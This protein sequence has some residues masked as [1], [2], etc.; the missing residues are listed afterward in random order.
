[1]AIPTRDPATTTTSLVVNW[2]GLV[3]PDNGYAAVLSYNLQW[4]SNTEG[5]TFFDLVGFET[6]SLVKSFT[7]VNDLVPGSWYSIRVRAKNYLGWG[8]FSPILLIQA[9]TYP[10]VSAPLSSLI[11]ETSG[12]VLIYWAEPNDSSSPILQYEIKLQ[13]KLQG[14]WT[15]DAALC[16]GSDPVVV[17]NRECL[18][19]MATLRAQYNYGFRD[20]VQA[21][22]RSYNAYGWS[23]DY[24]P[25]IQVGSATV[26]VEPQPV[27]Q[28]F[29]NPVETTTARISVYWDSFVDPTDF[30]D[31]EV[32]SYNLQWD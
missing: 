21:K 11:V 17:A 8:E 15:E 12:D 3:V 23:V 20:L 28:I 6:E 1:M 18:I 9:S 27:H 2:V 10:Q 19:P 25:E 24:S 30:G 13:D 14:T 26:R 32:T 4:D 22:L 7:I 5:T 16:D 29:V 31:S